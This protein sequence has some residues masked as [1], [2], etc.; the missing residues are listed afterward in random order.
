MQFKKRIWDFYTRSYRLFKTIYRQTIYRIIFSYIIFLLIATTLMMLPIAWRNADKAFNFLDTF[1]LVVS[2]FSTTGL[3]VVDVASQMTW[4][5]QFFLMILIIMGG[6]GLLFFKVSIFYFA[7]LFIF[8]T[9]RFNHVFYE[10]QDLERGYILRQKTYKM[11]SIGFRYLLLFELLGI[12]ALFCY[13]FFTPGT[14]NSAFARLDYFQNFG[15][16]FWSAIFHAVSAANNAGFD[17]FDDGKNSL[18]VFESHY[19]V[20]FVFIILFVL[21]G[22]GFP[23]FLEL[24]EKIKNRFKRNPGHHRF[25]F[26]VK[27][28]ILSYLIIT[29]LGLTTNFVLEASFN[30][31][32]VSTAKRSDKI[33]AVLFN[34]LSTRS[35]GFA[36]VDI[37]TDFVPATRLMMMLLMFIGS[38]PLSTGGGIKVTTLLI[39][40]YGLFGSYDRKN[41]L[42]IRNNT[43]GHRTVFRA[44]LI[45]FLA[46]L[47]V[48]LFV[49]IGSSA[50]HTNDSS[51][52]NALD[53]FFDGFSALGNAGLT[54]I[55]L[56]DKQWVFYKIGTI[57]LM[58]IGQLGLGNFQILV[59]KKYTFQHVRVP[60]KIIL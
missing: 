24:H 38:A 26:F 45:F 12:I 25:S 33:M 37:Q 28:S 27:F 43:I 36:T 11:L 34:T 14:A 29:M 58:L 1:H 19:F 46:M 39:L 52:P 22:I 2:G 40:V 47:V 7:G 31:D 55:G 35:A 5:G 49:M 32:F 44:F 20:Q 8:G 50:L 16:S 56:A 13:F 60:S 51:T 53:V 42:I 10:E 18:M 54:S 23:F 6:L 59:K 30:D 48:F 15:K 21:G 57:F 3:V 4:L 41:N 9:R 17:I